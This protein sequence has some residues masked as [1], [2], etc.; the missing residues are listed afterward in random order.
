MKLTK[1][2]SPALTGK[3]FFAYISILIVITLINFWFYF[4][5]LFQQIEKQAV[6]LRLFLRG[7]RTA[8]SDIY[9]IAL[10]ES[11]IDMFGDPPYG[12]DTLAHVIKGLQVLGVKAIGVDL[13]AFNW[14]Q[15]VTSSPKNNS[16]DSILNTFCGGKSLIV[17]DFQP[18]SPAKLQENFTP[19]SYKTSVTSLQ[20]SHLNF[21]DETTSL[22]NKKIPLFLTYKN[23]HIPAFFIELLIKGLKI[24]PGQISYQS[25]FMQ[26]VQPDRENLK[27]PLSDQEMFLVNPLG[28][29]GGFKQISSFAKIYKT[30]CAAEKSSIPQLPFT[31]FTDKFVLIGFIEDH[32]SHLE[33]FFNSTSA[34]MLHATALSN[35]LNQNFIYVASEQ[36]NLL[37]FVFSA[38]A[39]LFFVIFFKNHRKYLYLGSYLLGFTV[40][41][42]LIFSLKTILIKMTGPTIHLFG[43]ILISLIFDYWTCK[44]R[45]NRLSNKFEAHESFVRE[46]APV[47][48]I[49]TQP[50]YKIIISLIKIQNDLIIN[51]SIESDRDRR[52]GISPFYRSPQMKHPF[53]FKVARL[54][55]LQ[56]ELKRLEESYGQYVQKGIKND[57]RPI[58]LLKRIGEQVYKD[59]SLTT[60][61]DEL[62]E[63]VDSNTSINAIVDDLLI[64]WQWA[65]HPVRKLFL[66]DKFPFSYSFAIDK[67]D[68]NQSLPNQQHTTLI[69][70]QRSA[71]LL[72]GNW[73]G[74]Q[75]KAL[76]NVFQEINTIRQRI[77][78]ISAASVFSFTDAE[79]FLGALDNHV[80]NNSNLRLIH[81]SGHIEEGQLAIN[82][83]QSI[84]AGT[85]KHS[86]NLF[87]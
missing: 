63:I 46:N 34:F 51:H 40:M 39:S 20:V 83:K 65:Y 4:T 64:P 58:D 79:P 57:L 70:K 48:D 76:K 33:P 80:K 87:F 19:A 26:I 82:S 49:I 10:D 72:Y 11:T 61:L 2:M 73:T 21:Q 5:P 66:C 78:E 9:L 3:P 69:S 41:A 8:N 38:L 71:L 36:T 7:E 52:L 32:S 44:K 75:S 16:Q 55:R 43:F 60:T 35:V 45:A 67:A 29:N 15:P 68:F 6:E 23:H 81:Y 74:H 13:G 53:R 18:E 47:L 25:G 62:F 28:G 1:I 37:I 54:N 24:K 17:F 77:T 85:L 31:N 56:N 50:F 27:I 12:Y 30:C 59:F 86:K 42:I 84:H 14:S 22:S